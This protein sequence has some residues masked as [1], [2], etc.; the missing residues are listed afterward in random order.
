MTHTLHYTAGSGNS[1]KPA[2]VLRQTG[3]TCAM[4]A[5]DVLKGESRRPEYLAINARG[6]VPYLVTEDP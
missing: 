3:R 4:R 1:F 2:L 6:Q 5:V